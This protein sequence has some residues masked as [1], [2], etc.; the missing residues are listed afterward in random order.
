MKILSIIVPVYNVENYLAKCLDS[1]L[2][3]NLLADDYEI[4]VV[5]DGATDGS[6]NI[7]NA[8]ASKNVQIKVI[9]QPNGGLSDARNTGMHYAQGKYIQFVDSDDFLES[10]VL[11]HLLDKMEKENLDIL[12]Y[13]YQ[14]INDQ[15][16]I[17]E[18]YKTMKPFVDYSDS[19]T[20]GANFLIERL[21]YAC[22]AWQFIIRAE[23]L[24]KPENQ[25][26]KGIYFED[27]EWTPRIL[28]QATKITS[29][30]TVVYN[31]L[32]RVGS[33]TQSVVDEKKRKV[34]DDLLLSLDSINDLVSQK[35]E[36]AKWGKRFI[37]KTHINY[38][39]YLTLNLF[40][41]RKFYIHALNEKRCRPLSSDQCEGSLLT[42]INI[43]PTLFVWILK[44]KNR[45]K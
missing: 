21:G 33:I 38:L 37:A 25:F 31:Y 19:V 13:N 17:F 23:L 28:V 27:V 12:R 8:Y 45:F 35:P 4:I 44:L 9:E 43:S 10:N 5:I 41:M 40:S 22:Y 3:Q 34:L 11:K 7:A 14:N 36:L 24:L 2:C 26:K 20:N 30:D 39:R 42:I 6:L 29:V 15:N 18:P 32:M 16:E 1:L